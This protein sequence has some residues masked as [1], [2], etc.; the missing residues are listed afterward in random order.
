M[1]VCFYRGIWWRVHA[2]VTQ[3]HHAPVHEVALRLCSVQATTS[4]PQLQQRNGSH[5]FVPLLSCSAFFSN[6]AWDT[7]QSASGAQPG[8]VARERGA[9]GCRL[10]WGLFFLRFC[11][12]GPPPSLFFCNLRINRERTSCAASVANGSWQIQRSMR[13]RKVLLTTLVRAL[14]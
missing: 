1:P 13:W 12:C 8:R 10:F 2:V 5:H 7:A 9:P 14:W 4:R 11:A 6:P 3:R